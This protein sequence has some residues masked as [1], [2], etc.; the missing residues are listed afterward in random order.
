[1]FIVYFVSVFSLMSFPFSRDVLKKHLYK[2]TL[3]STNSQTYYYQS[4][5]IISKNCAVIQLPRS[6]TTLQHI[7]HIVTAYRASR[8]HAAVTKAG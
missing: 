4:S 1:M 8:Y 7:G 5:E 3:F 2:I 6:K